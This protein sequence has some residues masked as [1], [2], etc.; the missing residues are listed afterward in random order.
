[1]IVLV[2]SPV[3]MA[4]AIGAGPAVRKPFA[5]VGMTA[6]CAC[7]DSVDTVCFLPEGAVEM[8]GV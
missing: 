4:V 2:A 5:A 8:A 3:P 1:M 6:W 7:R